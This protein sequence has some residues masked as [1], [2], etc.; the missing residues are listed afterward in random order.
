[1]A[2]TLAALWRSAAA[3]PRDAPAYLVQD[4]DTWKPLSWDEAATR[5]DELANGLLALGVERGDRLAILA[6]STVEGALLDFA[7]L[8]I[9][10]G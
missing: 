6:P 9:G 2:A 1:M 3:K 5:V 7:P 10:A 8:T 4:E